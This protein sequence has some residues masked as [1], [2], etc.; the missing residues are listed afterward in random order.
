MIVCH[1]TP[2]IKEYRLL[3]RHIILRQLGILKYF[4]LFS[5]IVFLIGPFTLANTSVIML[6]SD[7]SLLQQYKGFS[8]ILILP[9]LIGL[10]LVMTH[11]NVSRMWKKSDEFSSRRKYILDDKGIHFEGNTFK[12]FFEWSNIKSVGL[13]RD[14]IFFMNPLNQFSLISLS[15]LSSDDDRKELLSFVV[16]HATVN[17]FYTKSFIAAG[18][19]R[20]EIIKTKSTSKT[21]LIIIIWALLVLFILLW[22]YFTR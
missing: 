12:G 14:T 7:L 1:Y 2:S 21:K 5:I 22:S 8:V 4:A 16:K 19:T 18:A 17:K 9:G 20:D 6:E 13:F 11:V 15:Q 3:F 10:M